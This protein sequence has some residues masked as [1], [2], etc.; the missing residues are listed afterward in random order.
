MWR[1]LIS[2]SDVPL[3]TKYSPVNRANGL[4]FKCVGTILQ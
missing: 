4:A 3:Q 1:K 2:F